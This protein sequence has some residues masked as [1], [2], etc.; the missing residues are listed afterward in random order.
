ML[1]LIILFF[2]E[3]KQKYQSSRETVIHFLCVIV[4]FITL[5]SHT[6][7][8]WVLYIPTTYASR[9]S[10]RWMK[11]KAC[12]CCRT[13][14]STRRDGIVHTM[15]S[16]GD[17]FFFNLSQ[18]PSDEGVSWRW[19]IFKFITILDMIRYLSPRNILLHC[20]GNNKFVVLR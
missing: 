9:Y 20:N 7:S 4:S 11:D 6:G 18:H 14:S 2:T 19:F 16:V 13:L 1:L 12:M 10:A 5:P 3:T 8:S 17:D 15:V